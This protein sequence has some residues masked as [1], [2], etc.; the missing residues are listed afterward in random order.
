MNEISYKFIIKIT[1]HLM[2]IETF[3]NISSEF[4]GNDVTRI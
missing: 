1:I 4:N 3:F 2:A